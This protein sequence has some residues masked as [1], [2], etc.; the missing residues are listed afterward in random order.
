[1]DNKL[2]GYLWERLKSMS[3]RLFPAV[4]LKPLHIVLFDEFPS[5][6]VLEVRVGAQFE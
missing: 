1:M 4:P 5:H 3:R 6:W 2:E